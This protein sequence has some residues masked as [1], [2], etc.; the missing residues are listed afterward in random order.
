MNRLIIAISFLFI[1]QGSSANPLFEKGY[2]YIR[3]FDLSHLSSDLQNWMTLQAPN[4]FIYV[5]NSSRLFEFDGVSWNTYAL[6]N[7]S[8]LR[9]LETDSTGKIFVGGT[10]EFGYFFPDDYG[11]LKYYSLSNKLDT[12]D[13]ESVWRI[14]KTSEGI[15]FIAG[16]K[17][18][19]KYANNRLKLI[20]SPQILADYRASVVEDQI[21]FYDVNAG[22]GKLVNDTM[23]IY[24]NSLLHDDYTVY[25]FLKG[26]RNNIITAVRQEGLFEFEPQTELYSWDASL[27]LKKSQLNLQRVHPVHSG[28]I[29]PLNLELNNILR[30]A[31]IYDA[32]NHKHNY[33]LATLRNGLIITDHEF[34][35]INSYRK[36]SGITSDAIY[37]IAFDR[38]ENLWLAG[39]SGLSFIREKYPFRYFD[40]RNNLEG[41][42]I[43]LKC[44]NDEILVGTTQGIF[45]INNRDRK[46][47]KWHNVEAISD[48]YIYI[49]DIEK[50]EDL[51]DKLLMSSLRNVLSFNLTTR[52]VESLASYYGTYDICNAP[53]HNQVY[54]LGHPEGIGVIKLSIG[55]RGEL[56]VTELNAF[57]DINA[58]VRRLVFDGQNRLWV[59]TAY[60][61]LILFRLD[62][63]LK[64]IES[65]RFNESNGFPHNDNNQP[66]L[67]DDTLFVATRSG[68]VYYNKKINKFKFY[69][70]LAD[71]TTFDTVI[72]NAVLPTAEKVWYGLDKG[73]MYYDRKE[74]KLV[75]EVF[76]RLSKLGAEDLKEDRFGNI[77]I[78]SLD[79][80]IGIDKM[81]LHEQYAKIPL[82]FRNI[83]FGEDSLMPMDC[84]RDYKSS[85]LD[86]GEIPFSHNSFQLNLACPAFQSMDEI[87]FSYKLEGLNSKWS[88]WQEKQSISFS[89]LPG[90]EYTLKVKAA[91]ANQ[92][93]IG[94]AYLKFEIL[95]PYYLTI[96]A[97]LFYGVLA[98]MLVYLI[99]KLYSR[100][101]QAEKKRLQ[102]RI[103]EAVSTVQQQKEELEQQ[104]S[105]LTETNKELEKLS[106]VAE[107]TDSAVA[108]MDGKGN[109]QWINKGFTRM[110][111]YRFNELLQDH[112]REK[113]GKHA[114]LT[115]N[116]LINVWFGDK[117]PIIYESLNKCKDG[118]ELWVQT[119][120]TPILD[121]QGNVKKLISIDTDITKLKEAEQEIER[122]RDEI[123]Q[124]RD[125][126]VDQRDKIS[127]QKQEITDSIHYAQRIQTALFPSRQTLSQVF[128]HNV[129]F[130][131]PR[132][133][134]SGDFYWVQ[135]QEDI[136][137]LAVAD[138]TGH[139]VP[140]AFMSLIGLNF[141]NEI[142]NYEKINQP[143]KVLNNL[144]DKII[145]ALR[146]TS[147]VGDNKDGM[148]IAFITYEPEGRILRYAGANNIAF[149]KRGEELI[150]LEP[151]K[152]PISIFRDIQLPFKLRQIETQPGDMLYMFSDGYTDQFGGKKGKKF[153]TNN[154]KKLLSKLP[155][156]DVENQEKLIIDRFYQWK[157][158]MDQIDD[159][160]VVGVKLE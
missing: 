43:S 3:N 49:L 79:K 149:I 114:N 22:F 23:R 61:G 104:T 152:M 46:K 148:D 158:D 26:K 126:A 38:Q 147:K 160:L 98:L 89:Y 59:S 12:I 42:A 102:Q 94:E 142:V 6:P 77:W 153:K 137:L 8:A 27:N 65:R 5:A 10:R 109:Y 75:N 131:S 91:D 48:E 55:N 105:Y 144:R 115:M 97:F 51:P 100:R 122:Q 30:D 40:N 58:N 157:G 159:V 37:H 32:V 129:V 143:D 134:V 17:H 56:D 154:F 151:D 68:V 107:Y 141:L 33:Y 1:L 106:I 19:F 76:T 74:R 123:R 156:G 47:Q 66:Y 45:S 67:L 21:Y 124:Q 116:D 139:G 50:I 71:I 150:E 7:N 85:F 103:D 2:P 140:G 132:D 28:W 118:S 86:L 101:L 44:H 90:G 88:G 4:G 125:Y 20:P 130:D 31:V 112:D 11:R 80:V 127:A 111:G 18:I 63:N 69:E 95:P 72:V 14:L 57:E 16:R 13:F 64:I 82:S 54:L 78:A 93:I 119:A 108:I 145:N 146:Q 135:K 60:N 155:K 9:S 24:K 84:Y 128:P 83:I 120:L 87:K 96:W 92:Q 52:K 35:I 34:N 113:I 36:N 53:G 39:E 62:E 136:A 121:D 133:I 41:V 110:Y 73:I 25:F 81:Y 117:K 70:P 15:Y 138:C 29:T 99:I